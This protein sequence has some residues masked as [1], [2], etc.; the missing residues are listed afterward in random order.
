MDL[1]MDQDLK[2]DTC[3][4]RSLSLRPFTFAAYLCFWDC[5]ALDIGYESNL[6][7]HFDLT[8]EAVL[9]LL[10]INLTFLF[11][12]VLPLICALCKQPWPMFTFQ[13]FGGASTNDLNH[14]VKLKP[15]TCTFVLKQFQLMGPIMWR[16][17]PSHVLLFQNNFD[18][19]DP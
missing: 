5:T 10:Q 12:F 1:C 16:R 7:C 18:Q 11:S 2:K 17:S 15:G 13:F 8:F 3:I 14:N 6:T 9:R 4:Y 19:W